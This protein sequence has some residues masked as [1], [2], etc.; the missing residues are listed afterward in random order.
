MRA[1]KRTPGCWLA[2]IFGQPCSS[3]LQRGTPKRN[4]YRCTIQP[5]AHFFRLPGNTS[6]DA[7]ARRF[8]KR[9]DGVRDATIHANSAHRTRAPRITEGKCALPR[10]KNLLLALSLI[11]DHYVD[12]RRRR[13]TTGSVGICIHVRATT[14][15]KTQQNIPTQTPRTSNRH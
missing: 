10:Q 15:S 6:I 13:E 5:A 9:R 4:H 7:V 1:R 2:L 3:R 11:C 8:P 14:R 12:G